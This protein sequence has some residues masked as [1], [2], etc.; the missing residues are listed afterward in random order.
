MIL[1]FLLLMLLP[2]NNARKPV[3]HKLIFPSGCRGSSSSS[4]NRSPR[5]SFSPATLAS[6]DWGI[7]TQPTFLCGAYVGTKWAKYGTHLGFSDRNHMW[8]GFHVGPKL[9]AHVGL[10]QDYTRSQVGPSQAEQT[11]PILASALSPM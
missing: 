6:F 4:S 8:C 7:P 5:T 1:L 2:G 11:R 3:F 9:I 10:K